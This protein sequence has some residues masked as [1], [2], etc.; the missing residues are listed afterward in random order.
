MIILGLDLALRRTGYALISA[1]RHP[2]GVATVDCSGVID[3]KQLPHDHALAHIAAC[4][5]HNVFQLA[6][7]DRCYV[8]VPGR[9][10]YQRSRSMQTVIALSEA[11]GAVLAACALDGIPVEE[12]DQAWVKSCFGTDRASKETIKW[13]LLNL[14]KAG[15]LAGFTV[16]LR[17]R[18]GDDEDRI[19]AVA[20]A[21]AG[22]RK[23]YQPVEYSR[24]R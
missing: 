18:G 4:L 24:T 8:E 21:V 11:K 20:V 13:A 3:T 14:T 7:I 1:P 19:D 16:P 2:G 23:L 10:N 17:P 9:M 22:Y 5:A 15:L 12:I 6:A